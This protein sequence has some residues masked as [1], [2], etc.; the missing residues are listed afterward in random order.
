[1]VRLQ[2]AGARGMAVR[3]TRLATC[4]SL[5]VLAAGCGSSC[6]QPASDAPVTDAGSADAPPCDGCY[7]PDDA[8]EDAGKDTSAKDTGL[9]IPDVNA[10]DGWHLWPFAPSDT[11][12]FV[13]DDISTVEGITWEPC[14]F[15]PQGCEM[16]GA[17]WKAVSG[18]GFGTSIRAAASDAGTLLTF[19]RERN[20]HWDESV[21][22]AGGDV[23]SVFAYND[24]ES[25]GHISHHPGTDGKV[26][27]YLVRNQKLNSPYAYISSPET[28]ATQPE[29]T[30]FFDASVNSYDMLTRSDRLLVMWEDYGRF[31]VRDL[32]TG[33]TA[34][35]Q[36]DQ[37]FA[38]LEMPYPV[39]DAVIYEAWTGYLGS[40][41]VW[42]ADGK[43]TRVLGDDTYS[44]DFPATDGSWVV[45]NKGTDFIKTNWFQ[46]VELWAS[47]IGTD[48]RKLEPRKLGTIPSGGLCLPA[49]GDGWVVAGISD[50]E[51]R[52]WRL[53]DGA[54]KYIPPPPNLTLIGNG[55]TMGMV[56]AGGKVW[57][58]AATNPY[59]SNADYIL[60][61]DIE[62]LPDL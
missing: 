38:F 16:A 10:P 2:A 31:A 21:V 51:T 62:S 24:L 19:G 5:L 53:S 8:D 57:V 46:T 11:A 54:Q 6:S 55:W 28:M 43:N 36:P 56:I 18:W 12:I 41:W 48:I 29:R 44:Y 23:V 45:W 15:Q 30:E 4:A 60:R 1:M 13:P 17:P 27:A 34:H 22:V 20:Q 50:T 26:A 39:G 61:Y 59:G 7:V 9:E 35:P 42:T 49:L 3:L 47:P 58:S 32:Q 40:I 52:L 33:A 25:S 14:P 37:D